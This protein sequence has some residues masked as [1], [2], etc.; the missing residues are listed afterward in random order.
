MG[1]QKKIKWRWID[2]QKQGQIGIQSVCSSRMSGIWRNFFPCYK[3]WSYH[4]VFGFCILQ[5]IQSL[6]DGCQINIFEWWPWG[7]SLRGATIRFSDNW[8]KGLCPPI[9]ESPVWAK[10]GSKSLVLQTRQVFAPIRISEG[11]DW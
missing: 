4:D 1:I 2:S 10:T 7:R 6:P 11:N 5:E 3:N 8:Q 9:K